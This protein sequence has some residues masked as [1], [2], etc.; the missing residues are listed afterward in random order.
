MKYA[1]VKGGAVVN[2]ID[3]DGVTPYAAPAECSVYPWSGPIDIGWKWIDGVPVQP[4]I[5]PSFEKAAEDAR[6][7]RNRMLS[8]S[9][10]TQLTDAPVDSLAWANYRQAL[11]DVPQQAGFPFS[12]T[13]P[14]AP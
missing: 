2:I 9:D 5:S 1:I 14:V 8:A 4:N 10:W 13:W 12:V 3:W 11:R 7:Q 6:A